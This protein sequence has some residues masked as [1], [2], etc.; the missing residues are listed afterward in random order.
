M[1]ETEPDAILTAKPTLLLTEFGGSTPELMVAGFVLAVEV[2]LEVA[3][4]I[5]MDEGDESEV[6]SA[7]YAT[8][9]S[10]TEEEGSV[11]DCESPVEGLISAEFWGVASFD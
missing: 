10:P 5:N 4:A 8:P 2:V 7:G 3:V 1:V 9:L 6:I 11:I